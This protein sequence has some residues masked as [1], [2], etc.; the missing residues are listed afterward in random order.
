[1]K[2]LLIASLV[3]SCGLACADLSEL[4]QG[5]CGNGIVDPGEDCDLFP[6]PDTG[7]DTR[8]GIPDDGAA[9]CRYLCSR[10][11]P[12][13]VCPAGWGCNED[14]TCHHATGRFELIGEFP[15]TALDL[16]TGDVDGDGNIDLLESYGTRLEVHFGSG[17]G[18]FAGTFDLPISRPTGLPAL[19][20]LDV[21]GRTDV[22]VPTALG[23]MVALGDSDR[24]LR[25]N[26]YP[27][28]DTSLLFGNLV[29]RGMSVTPL[30][31]AMFGPFETF[32]LLLTTPTSSAMFIIGGDEQ[33]SSTPLPPGRTV[34]QLIGRIPRAQLD[35]TPLGPTEEFVLAFVRDDRVWLYSTAVQ[36]NPAGNP[37]IVPELRQMI[38]LPGMVGASPLL[39][40]VDGDG[41][42]DLLVPLVGGEVAV[43]LGRVDGQGIGDFGIANVDLRFTA[44]G[45]PITAGDVNA[46]GLMDYLT[47]SGLQVGGVDG[48]GQ[49]VLSPFPL[50]PSAS[51]RDAVIAD[52]NRDGRLDLAAITTTNLSEVQVYLQSAVSLFNEVRVP[53]DYVPI[54]LRTGDFDGDLIEDLAF[55]ERISNT[56]GD[57]LSIMFGDTGGVPG[58]PV[59]VA[60]LGF[61]DVV[62]PGHFL[63]LGDV[64]GRTDLLVV[65]NSQLDGAGAPL[66]TV[67]VGAAERWL[68]APFLLWET[69][70]EIPLTV[71]I[72]SFGPGTGQFPGVVA[73]TR[74]NTWSLPGAP[75]A[76]FT[77]A[78]A[79]AHPAA[80]TG[81]GTV[82]CPLSIAAE[83]DGVDT[84][85]ELVLI[86]P[87]IRCGSAAPSMRV[88]KTDG[89]NL[90]YDSPVVPGNLIGLAHLTRADIDGSGRHAVILT[91]LG[92]TEAGATGT[93]GVLVLHSVGA[94]GD[95][96]SF[97]GSVLDDFIDGD[98]P[99]AAAALNVDLDPELEL[100]IL[101]GA[102]VVLSQLGDDGLFE[103]P[104]APIIERLIL[105]LQTMVTADVNND[106]L[107]DLI[108]TD[109]SSVAVYAAIP[110]TEVDR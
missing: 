8:C 7:P 57:V 44:A 9:A 1:M 105:G 53:T 38:P 62:E 110:H 81:I 54:G 34:P 22:V 24:T 11:D 52:F 43:A 45:W 35:T 101:T 66:L 100:A 106:G 86:D 83:L 77:R 29:P 50:P 60:P 47:A 59:A 79:V 37:E 6:G 64:D 23:L 10:T 74:A 28:L 39:V 93:S 91:F 97:R 84:S 108:F 63:F 4:E 103:P 89:T 32:L 51:W 19:G 12:D 21:D 96:I 75:G 13:P 30:N 70:P 26:V 87:W 58:R 17:D 16:R 56:E 36:N 65:S 109:G 98:P 69:D 73:V 71:A 55:A 99:R 33:Q 46:D 2:R 94:D 25:P 82:S 40:H 72:G 85:E 48:G 41:I 104:G 95:T 15:S 107:D 80:T 90:T 102:G 78:D 92:P 27:T 18:A 68:L 20:D 61:L 31:I 5:V 88:A 14:D 49:P 76:Q 67:L 42:V 3:A